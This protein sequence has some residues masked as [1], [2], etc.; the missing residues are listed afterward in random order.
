MFK[1]KSKAW[2]INQGLTVLIS[3]AGEANV[4]VAAQHDVLYAGITGMAP[5]EMSKTKQDLMELYGWHIEAD[6]D[7]WAIYT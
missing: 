2:K 1:N 5:Q 7:S 3:T 6:V 4:D